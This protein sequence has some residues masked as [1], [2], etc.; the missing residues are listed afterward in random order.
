MI[1]YKIINFRS[2]LG[3]QIV[4]TKDL[5]GIEVRVP[6]TINDARA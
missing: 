3:C 6:S 5:D 2:R 1:N 4:M